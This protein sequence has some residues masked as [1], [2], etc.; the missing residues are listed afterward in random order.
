MD[1]TPMDF[2][3]WPCIKA[4]LK[5]DSGSDLRLKVAI[6]KAINDLDADPTFCEACIADEFIKR[7][8]RCISASGG[9]FE[10]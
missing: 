3:L 7:V 10:C 9:N 1:L 2:A 6:N 8:K 5:D 4:K